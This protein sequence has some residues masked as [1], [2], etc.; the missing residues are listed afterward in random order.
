MKLLITGSRGMLG[1]ALVTFAKG[2]GYVL[3]TPSHAELDLSKEADVFGYF[4]QFKPEAIIHTAAPVGGIKFSIE[5]AFHQLSQSVL[6][7]S[8]ITR[9]AKQNNIKN[10]IYVGSTCMYP[11]NR[12]VAMAE[13][14]LLTGPLEQTNEGYALAKLVGAKTVELVSQETQFSWRTFILSNLYG[15]GDRFDPTRSH[16]VAAI[17][18][19]VSEAHKNG[20]KEVEMWGSG[21]SFREFTYVNDVAE[22]MIQQLPNLSMLP[23]NLNIG[24]GIDYSIR[25]Y[26]EMVCNV[27][28][29][30]GEI[31]PILGMSEG[32]RKKLSDI[33]LAR[34]HGWSPKISI[35][36]GLSETIKWYESHLE[37]SK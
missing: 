27:I 28:G 16:L 3:L 6:I 9:A 7:D 29:Y 32:M 10:F 31:K 8:N 25:Q 11:R 33:T 4:E 15:P 13:T 34:K 14:E 18:H 19:K 23:Q 22:F 36:T 12:D 26:Y 5:N 17:I 2:A 35:E 37:D 24:A 21:S 30:K 20:F 1:S